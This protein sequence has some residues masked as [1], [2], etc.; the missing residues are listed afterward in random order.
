[1]Q[2]EIKVVLANDFEGAF[3]SF[4]KPEDANN[5]AGHVLFDAVDFDQFHYDY[6]TL[7]DDYRIRWIN[8][9]YDLNL[10]E[11]PATVGF[12]AEDP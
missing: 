8:M 4:D 11:S 10:I 1:M 6:V 5:G 3:S 9:F 7:P 2:D 12:D